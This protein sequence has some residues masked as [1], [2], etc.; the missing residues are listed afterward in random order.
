MRKTHTTVI[1]PRKA[2]ENGARL[3][4]LAARADLLHRRSQRETLVVERLCD[5]L[6]EALQLSQREQA[7]VVVYADTRLLH[8][9]EGALDRLD[10]GE[11]GVCVDCG[12]RIGQRRL[13]ALP[14]APRCMACQERAEAKS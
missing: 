8:E 6:D 4:L 7:A 3:A 12:E 13:A 5:P 11:Y 2:I 10:A 14:W 1:D 9:I